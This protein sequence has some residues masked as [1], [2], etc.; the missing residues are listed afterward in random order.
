M[1]CGHHCRLHAAARTVCSA[2][3]CCVP[4]YCPL[5]AFFSKTALLSQVVRLVDSCSADSPLRE[6]WA[7]KVSD[8]PATKVRG[9]QALLWQQFVRNRFGVAPPQV[10]HMGAT[11]FN[12]PQSS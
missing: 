6:S 11:R 9:A 2:P 1:A 5:Q 10:Y 7:P 4:L 12:P 8:R 3:I